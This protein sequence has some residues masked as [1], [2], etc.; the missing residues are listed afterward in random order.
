MTP[1]QRALLDRDTFSPYKLPNNAAVYSVQGTP[2][3]G[4]Y[5][6]S[7]SNCVL[8]AD[9]SGNSAEN[10]LVLPGV[11]SNVATATVTFPA[12]QP[13]YVLTVD[14]AMPS[15]SAP[16][17][18]CV[19][20]SGASGVGDS[21]EIGVSGTT[22]NAAVIDYTDGGGTRR[23]FTLANVYTGFSAFSRH[24]LKFEINATANP[25]VVTVYES[26]DRGA[27]WSQLATT[28]VAAAVNIRNTSRTKATV[29]GRD[30]GTVRIMPD[31]TRIYYVQELAAIGGSA[32]WDFTP[33]NAAKLAGG[34]TSTAGTVWTIGTT[35]IAQ[36]ARICGARDR[37]QLTA[38]KQPAFS[39]GADGINI[40]TYDGVN[41]YMKSAPFSLSQPESTYFTGS[42][43]AW[44]NENRGILDGNAAESMAL[45]QAGTTPEVRATSNGSAAIANSNWPPA[46]RAVVTAIFNGTSSSLQVNQ[47]TAT[48]GN[49]STVAGGGVTVGSRAN[50]VTYSNITEAEF[51]VRSAADDPALKARIQA[52]FIRKLKIS[53]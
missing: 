31:G 13:S 44:F 20:V 4:T 29:G 19:F 53:A 41:D 46:T 47:G 48:T 27:S 8:V 9:R 7:G 11:G 15:W 12:T 18:D 16:G 39:T 33:A 17:A 51:F 1:A 30:S 22:S 49:T 21:T 25:H 35:A 45:Y 6:L 2:G 38:S 32:M 23:N 52:F 37:V 5:L 50:Q 3:D 24:L 36:P 42:Q 40:L 28:T 26:T 34:F 10:C 14:V 43:L